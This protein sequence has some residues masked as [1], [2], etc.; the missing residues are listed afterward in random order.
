MD[1]DGGVEAV[2]TAIVD[3]LALELGPSLRGVIAHGSWIHGDFAPSRSDVDLLVVL[4]HDPSPQTIRRIEPVLSG[5]VE[6]HPSWR[7]R[8]EL[9]FVTR[10]AVDDVIGG[11]G[12]PHQAARISPGEPLHLV[13]AARH[14]V[15]DWDAATRGIA[16]YGAAPAELLPPIPAPIVRSVVREHLEG[17]PTW[18]QE[19]DTS[20]PATYGSQAYAVLTVSRAAAL[21]RTNERLSKRQAAHWAATQFPRWTHWIVWA[22]SW[23]YA[24]GSEN[25]PPPGD[26]GTLSQL[27]ADLKA[28]VDD[29]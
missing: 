12:T 16:L 3:A 25:D 7:D 2:A 29:R 10:Q 11:A 28:Q 18:I 4:R 1:S 17:W 24:G 15:L 21:L 27:V 8:I 22:E 20:D 5:I 9:G 6:A 14:Q 19:A 26:G 13:P 23:W